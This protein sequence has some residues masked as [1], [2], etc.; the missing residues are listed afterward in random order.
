M[1]A[2]I[3]LVLGS[4]DS[5]DW[6]LTIHLVTKALVVATIL[7]VLGALQYQAAVVYEAF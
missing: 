4:P 5:G 6:S 3:N 2:V 1:R 7:L